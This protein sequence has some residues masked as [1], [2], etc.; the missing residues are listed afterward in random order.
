MVRQTWNEKCG[1]VKV[2]IGLRKTALT[3]NCTSVEL[4]LRTEMTYVHNRDDKITSQQRTRWYHGDITSK[5]YSTFILYLVIL[6]NIKTLVDIWRDGFDIGAKLLLNFE[7][8]KTIFIRDKID[9][10]T[11]MTITTW[12]TNPMKVCLRQLW[13]IKVDDNIHRLNVDT[14]RE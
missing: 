5:G 9:S 2:S 8:I 7:K 1:N 6:C 4:I 10:K 14:S 12:A 11:K 3:Q 13:K